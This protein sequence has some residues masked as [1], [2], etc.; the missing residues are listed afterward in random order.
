MDDM[1]KEEHYLVKDNSTLFDHC[2]SNPPYQQD[3]NNKSSKIYPRFFLMS[4][5]V[6]GHTVMIFPQG[7][8]YSNG[9][10]YIFEA[11]KMHNNLS[12]CSVDVFTED[13]QAPFRVFQ[14][15]TGGVSVV[16]SAHGYNNRF[17]MVHSANGGV[18]KVVPTSFV[19]VQ[20]KGMTP[21]K[22][23]VVEKVFQRGYSSMKGRISG[24]ARYISAKKFKMLLSE[25]KA[26]TVQD[27]I[28]SI[29]VIHK[30]KGNK[31]FYVKDDGCVSDSYGFKLVMPS[32]GTYRQHRDS[33]VL[34]PG[35][36]STDAFVSVMFSTRREAENFQKY[37]GTTFYSMLLKLGTVSHNAARGAH[38]F[39]PDLGDYTDNN[40][41]IDWDQP[42]DPQLYSLFEISDG[43]VMI[44]E[45]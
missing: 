28:Y 18:P 9:T 43:D 45:L 13:E 31:T 26:S 33:F 34:S 17:G 6:G 25:G 42:L 10:G 35:E 27:D 8:L 16:V 4:D 7:W 14:A 15:G 24:K 29:K 44:M 39:V 11:P 22:M 41:D 38:Q 37:L 12:I 1:L 36:V 32:T 19:Y 3:V 5:S 21:E 30:D 20:S 40:P 2:V 23:R